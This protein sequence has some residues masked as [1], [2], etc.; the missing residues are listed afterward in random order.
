M[1]ENLMKIKLDEQAQASAIGDSGASAAITGRAVE[2][3][4]AGAET[5]RPLHAYRAE[6]EAHAISRALELVGWN[7]RRAAEL[8]RISYRGLLYKIQ[9]YRI[10]AGGAGAAK[11]GPAA[12]GQLDET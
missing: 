1:S 10:T 5:L 12:D 9:Q 6:A 4:A 2:D 3:I 8:L 11:G 7:R